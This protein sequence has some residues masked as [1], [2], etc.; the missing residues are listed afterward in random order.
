MAH[1]GSPVTASAP[2]PET[3]TV[4][5]AVVGSGAAGLMA[6][7]HALRAD[8]TL[9]VALVSKGLAGRSGCS[10]MALGYNAAL[11]ADDDPAIHFSDLV[12]GGAFLSDQSLAWAVAGDAPAVVRELADEL[13]CAFDRAPDGSVALGPFAGQSRHRKVQRGHL[14][15]L[16]IVSR[17][18]DDLH[19]T[20]PLVLEDTRVLD[21]LVDDRGICGLVALD[22]R[23]G[24]P[25]VVVAPVV[26]LAAGGSIAS[27]YRVA[28]PAREKAGDGLAMA[29]RAGLP[30]R[31]MEM[32]QFLSVG[33]AAGASKLTG[34]LLEEAMRFAG[35]ELWNGQ[36][37]RFM[38][39]YD[40][41]GERA[42]RDVVAAACWAEIADGRGTPEGGVLLDC[43]PIGREM[44]AARF[45]DLVDRA[46]LVGVDLAEAPVP[47]APAAH[48]GI[49]GVVIDEH[50]TTELPGLLVAGEDAGGV[51]GASWAGGNGIA[52]STVFGRRAGRQAASIAR[53]RIAPV[54]AAAAATDT[55]RRAFAPLG[56]D[57][58][59]RADDLAGDL[60]G[61]LWD[62]VG[63][64]RDAA[65]LAA[66]TERIGELRER[67]STVSV[68][69]PA[70]ANRP[71]QDAL[72]FDSRLAVAEAVV[73]AAAART[74]SRGVHLRRDHPARDDAAWLRTVV[75]QHAGGGLSATTRP[76]RVDRL[77]P[78]DPVA[79]G[80]P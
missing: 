44:L 2:T 18:R 5:V 64:R 58:G 61:A 29:L 25:F 52:E 60:G 32:V 80:T 62:L 72:D 8:P 45:G 69:G 21:L 75:V 49:G 9:R 71:W 51:H 59:S 65:G 14:T 38:E 57:G 74:E 37:G 13:G 76:I 26:V 1:H 63:L 53:A 30:L 22:I 16:E 4:D 50:C 34:A 20:R 70:A 12:R 46:R 68:A 40:E 35:A 7:R 79:A 48:I 54:P 56:R 28:T 10:V 27:S 33:L 3:V 77:H 47:I 36:G 42:P 43:R 66:A 39:R 11:G 6:V 24:V 31:D 17:L 78:D 19:L 55:I 23:R 67:S 15:G 73:T 41:R